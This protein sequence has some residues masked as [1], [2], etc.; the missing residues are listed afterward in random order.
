MIESA[1][2]IGV[3]P[4]ELS[5]I[6]PAYNAESTLQRTLQSLDMIAADH[7]D[8]CSVVIVD[9]GSTDDTAAIARRWVDAQRTTNVWNH[10]DWRSQANGGAA[11]GRNTGLDATSS[12]WIH[13][14]DADDE[15]LI[16]PIDVLKQIPE[17]TTSVGLSLRYEKKSGRCWTARPPHIE[18]ATW[19]DELTA[20]NPFQPSS[21]LLR[22]ECLVEPFVAGIACVED[23]LFWMSN[24]PLFQRYHRR[25]DIIA[26][27]I[28]L[29]DGNISRQYQRAGT[30]RSRVAKTMIDRLAEDLTRHQRNNLMIQ[31]AIGQLQSGSAWRL[32][33]MFNMPA[34]MRLRLKYTLYAL[35]A[36]VGLRATPY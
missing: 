22:R 32:R 12:T 35:A 34:D 19:L 17:D 28:H 31:D 3:G 7:R 11:A 16:D 4:S 13:F 21:L 29:H 25:A 26:A 14:L 2:P 20:R 30:N 8:R 6:I 15:L 9:D 5:V 1:S 18:A 10:V 24:P 33:P 36:A 23:W 27:T